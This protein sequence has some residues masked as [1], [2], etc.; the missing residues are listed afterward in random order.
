[1]KLT[2]VGSGTASP[3]AGRVCPGFW[4][5]AGDERLLLDCG[6]GVV[7]GMARLAVPWPELDHLLITHFHNDHIGD[8]PM[9]LFALKHGVYPARNKPLTIW[10]PRGIRERLKAM[11]AAFG[12]H[13]AD[14]GFPVVIR[15]V[16]ARASFDVGRVGVRA[17]ATPHTDDSLAYRL[18]QNGVSLGYTGDTGPSEAVG[19]FMKG[20]DVLVA[21][22]SLPDELA[23]ETHLSPSSLAEMAARARP[24]RLVVT[25]VYPP[26]DVLGPVDRVRAAGWDGPTVRATDGLEVDVA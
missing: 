14:P 13:V 21:E 20:V 1:M 26:L 24:G 6:G 23:I 18:Q 2:V 5:E 11:E 9:L 12:D 17:S 7:H 15:E 3:E 19:T 4:V 10:A 8:I 25:H 22:C 16:S